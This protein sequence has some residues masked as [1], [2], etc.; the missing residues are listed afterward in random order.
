MGKN[1]SSDNA[2]KKNQATLEEKEREGGA[3]WNRVVE[4]DLSEVVMPFEQR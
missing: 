3:V 2:A 1:I 4:E